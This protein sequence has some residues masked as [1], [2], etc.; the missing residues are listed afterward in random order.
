M[1]AENTTLLEGIKKFQVI[2]S[3]Y[4]EVT[5]GDR[6]GQQPSKKARGK[7]YGGTVVKMEGANCNNLYL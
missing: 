1:I 6:E 7:Y 2:E 4:K 5:S 3:K